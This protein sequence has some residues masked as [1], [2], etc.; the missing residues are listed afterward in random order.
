MGLAGCVRFNFIPGRCFDRRDVKP[1]TLLTVEDVVVG[2]NERAT[3][4]IGRIFDNSLI[5]TS[6][7]KLLIEH[8]RLAALTLRTD[9]HFLSVFQGQPEG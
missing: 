8:N 2:Q 7:Q 3:L 1:I 5:R 4:A 6:P 9:L